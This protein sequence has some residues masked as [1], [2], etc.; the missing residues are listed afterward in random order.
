[1]TR[2]TLTGLSNRASFR[3]SLGQ[4]L[5][6]A[7]R[8]RVAVAVWFLDLD[9][10]KAIN[11]QFGHHSGDQVLVEVAKRLER[12]LRDVD[13]VARLGGDEFAVLLEN[14]S[15]DQVRPVAERVCE[16]LGAPY[17]LDDGEEVKTGVSIGIAMSPECG[18]SVDEILHRADEAMYDAK[19]A[20]GGGALL[21]IG[22]A[23]DW[24]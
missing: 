19:R 5:S 8:S 23:A 1:M 9:R 20:G 15:A 24:P 13:T 7:L 14:V 12:T 17:R 22:A 6:R 10:F 2:D 11:D 4:A 18:S 16:S 21:R 3:G